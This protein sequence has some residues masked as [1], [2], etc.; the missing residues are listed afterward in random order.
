MVPR[1]SGV[2]VAPV[3]PSLML[4]VPCRSWPIMEP[5]G[6][7]YTLLYWATDGVVFHLNSIDTDIHHIGY[8]PLHRLSVS[9]GMMGR[10]AMSSFFP[11][12]RLKNGGDGTDRLTTMMMILIVVLVVLDWFL[13][14]DLE[15]EFS[16][17]VGDTQLDLIFTKTLARNKKQENKDLGWLRQFKLYYLS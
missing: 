5:V 13:L 9:R 15:L 14:I 7:R 16:R 4:L 17:D 3:M 6:R 8:S 11:F 12:S 10:M 2:Y 1:S